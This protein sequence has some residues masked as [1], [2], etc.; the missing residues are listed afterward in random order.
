MYISKS[1]KYKLIKK[2]IYKGCKYKNC[3]YRE[4]LNPFL[5][6][7]YTIL[8][9]FDD[10]FVEYIN[11][12]L[13][14]LQTKNPNIDLNLFYNNLFNLLI[15]EK[16]NFN[17]FFIFKTETKGKYKYK[18][19]RI[20]VLKDDYP[21]TIFHELLHCSSSKKEKNCFSIGFYK[22]Y[23]DFSVGAALNEGYTTLLEERYFVDSF[24]INDYNN[25]RKTLQRKRHSSKRI[26]QEIQF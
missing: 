4:N 16:K 13:N 22:K 7:N 8:K 25:N 20:E 11:S 19:N 18:N 10:T 21:F 23:K 26:L 5:K 2:N 3:I 6:Q 24:R 14:T 15:K 12:F 1:K 9:N 17:R